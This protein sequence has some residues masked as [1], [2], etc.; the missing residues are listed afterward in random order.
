MQRSGIRGLNWNPANVTS[1]GIDRFRE[2]FPELRDRPI[3]GMLA[4]LAVDESVLRYAEKRGFFVLA[5]GDEVMEF[6]NRPGFEPKRWS[7]PCN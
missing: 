6:K 1:V 7:W 5:V 4:T 2:F 3:V